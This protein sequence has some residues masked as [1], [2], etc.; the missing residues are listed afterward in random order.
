MFPTQLLIE[1][2]SRLPGRILS[3]MA[4]F[5]LLAA[6]GCTLQPPES[7]PISDPLMAPS[8]Q[9]P[10][11]GRTYSYSSDGQPPMVLFKWRHG[12]PTKQI[13]SPHQ[14]ERFI[15]CV[16]DEKLGECE[17]GT[18]EGV[19][20]PI[21]LEV[22]ADDPVVYRRPIEQ[23]KNPFVRS[24]NVNIGYEFRTS[25]GMHP[26]YRD[27]SL[28]WQVGA[29]SGGTCRMSDPQSLRMGG[30]GQWNGGIGPGT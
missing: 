22:A 9:A 30:P 1:S 13:P 6:A 25:L 5:L 10:P 17:S 24:P 4:G 29:C 2:V 3:P 15:I 18:R 11:E 26:E 7:E 19:P 27:R 8:P 12:M 14:A 23:E 16:Y 28:L 20:E 21:W